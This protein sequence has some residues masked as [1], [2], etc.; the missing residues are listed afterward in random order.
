MKM[1]RKEKRTDHQRTDIA[2]GFGYLVGGTMLGTW[3]IVFLHGW[4]QAVCLIPGA[5]LGAASFFLYDGYIGSP[6]RDR[7]FA[8]MQREAEAARR[9]TTTTAGNSVLLNPNAG[10]YMGNQ[11]AVRDHGLDVEGDVS[12]TR[13]R[14]SKD[15]VTGASR[16]AGT[17]E[18]SPTTGSGCP[19]RTSRPAP[20]GA[21]GARRG[22]AGV[23]STPS[24]RPPTS[25][26]RG[27]CPRR[28]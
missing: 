27:L 24:T 11:H 4:W 26:E 16:V 23:G 8:Q 6:R 18:A 20:T 25:G 28:G 2:V 14:R 12:Q 5:M 7:V 9:N 1:K 3:D 15:G 21:G 19:E 10:Y 17:S 13:P 22:R